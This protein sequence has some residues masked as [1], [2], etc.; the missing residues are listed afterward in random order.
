MSDKLYFYN[1]TFVI[2]LQSAGFC[3]QMSNL[4]QHLL[5]ERSQQMELVQSLKQKSDHF[6]KIAEKG[7]QQ[8]KILNQT[9]Q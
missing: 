1:V 3:C 7:E 9:I 8:V 5:V 2:K 4:E 6:Q